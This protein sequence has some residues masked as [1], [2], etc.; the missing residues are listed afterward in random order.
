MQTGDDQQRG[1]SIVSFDGGGPGVISELVMMEE[2]MERMAYDTDIEGNEPNL[3][4]CWDLMGGV[5]F[6]G[7]AALLLGRLCMTAQE[8][9]DELITIGKAIFPKEPQEKS[10]E[11]NTRGLRTAVEDMLRRNG[12]FAD[13]K[14]RESAPTRCKV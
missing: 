14:L 9:M 10:P 12:H 11:E 6:G 5:G 4:E 1:I 2:F 3:T 7:L 8:A 13:L